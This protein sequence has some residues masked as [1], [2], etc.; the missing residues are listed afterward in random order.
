MKSF[1]T[2]GMVT[3]IWLTSWPVKSDKPDE[4]QLSLSSQEID[5]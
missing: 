2:F 4:P 3:E 1:S 5:R